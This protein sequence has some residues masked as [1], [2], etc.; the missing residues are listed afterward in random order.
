LAL[1]QENVLERLP[2]RIK[3]CLEDSITR[4]NWAV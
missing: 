4:P 3:V 1:Q 2:Y